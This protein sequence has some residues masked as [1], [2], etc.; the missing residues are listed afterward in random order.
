MLDTATKTI[1]LTIN[2]NEIRS[3]VFSFVNYWLFSL[4][5][6]TEEERKIVMR[7]LVYVSVS[8]GIRFFRSAEK[9]RLEPQLWSN[10]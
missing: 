1:V 8:P 2:S 5:L 10:L 4:E 6:E 9:S 7:F 3:L